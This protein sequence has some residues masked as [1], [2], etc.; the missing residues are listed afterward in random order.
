ME[1]NEVLRRLKKIFPDKRVEIVKRLLGGMSNYTYVI[2]LDGQLYTFRIPG[3]F[4]EFFVNRILEKENL[5]LIEKLGISNKTIYFDVESGEKVATYIEGTP[6][7]EGKNYPYKEIAKLL[8]KI[9]HSDLQS[10]EDYEPFLRLQQYESYNEDLGFVLPEKYLKIRNKFLYYKNILD[11]A[12]KVLCHG[13]SQPSNFI[14]SEHVLHLVDFEFTANND[15]IYDIACFANIR[16]EDGLNLLKAYFDD[17]DYDMLERFYLWRAFQALQWYNVAIF[18][19]IKGM[20]K[21]LKI[22]FLEVASK[23]L[24]LA[25]DLMKKV[26]NIS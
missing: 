1:E 21:T 24:L 3:E 26:E 14:L 23:Y 6:L 4:S 8:K 2:K 22:D 25:T 16:L 9:H 7:H 12:P 15:P 18:K 19:D 17:V 11:N 10:Q 5:K 13:D 20:S